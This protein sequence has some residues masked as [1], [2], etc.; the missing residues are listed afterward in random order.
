VKLFCGLVPGYVPSV[1]GHNRVSKLLEINW[2]PIPEKDTHGV[3][4]GYVVYFRRY[5]SYENFTT[6][7][8]NA[9]TRVL[10][11]TGVSEAMRYEIKVAGRTSVGEGPLHTTYVITGW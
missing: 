3:L 2:S 6:V 5:G 8:V 4:L 7:R 11:I 10:R 9:S 1:Y